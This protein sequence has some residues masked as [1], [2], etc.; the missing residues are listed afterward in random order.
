MLEC[1]F[2]PKD[3]LILHLF[4]WGADHVCVGSKDTP[5]FD[6]PFFFPVG[7]IPVVGPC[8]CSPVFENGQPL[9]PHEIQVK[10]YLCCFIYFISQQPESLKLPSPCSDIPSPLRK[11]NRPF[12][13]SILRLSWLARPE[14][15]D[16]KKPRRFA[17]PMG[18]FV[19]ENHHFE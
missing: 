17:G 19:M 9:G 4:L 6:Q 16:L 1:I 12:A 15:V 13:P 5:T 10:C 8:C 14:P 3:F 2:L 11:A 7:W 18:E